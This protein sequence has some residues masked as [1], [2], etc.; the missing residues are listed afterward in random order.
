[1]KNI[2]EQTKNNINILYEEEYSQ[3]ENEIKHIIVKQLD[4]VGIMCRVFSRTKSKESVLKKMDNKRM[5]KYQAENRGMQDIL[6]IRVIVYFEDDIDICIN[7]I[8]NKFELI[9]CEHDVN[10][11]EKFCPKRINYI[12]GIPKECGEIPKEIRTKCMME[13]TFEVQFRTVFSEGWH[14]VEH[15]LRYKNQSDWEDEKDLAR[16]LNALF[17]VLEMC[18]SNLLGICDN[19]AYKKYKSRNWESM[20]RNRFRLR[21]EDKQLTKKI[22]DVFEENDSIGKDIFRFERSHLISILNEMGE[23]ITYENVIFIVNYCKTRDDMLMC[24]TPSSIMDRLEELD[25]NKLEY[26]NKMPYKS[27]VSMKYV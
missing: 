22:L 16:D 12:F 27:V 20:I 21:F 17:A 1:M 19:L 13:N 4:S 2:L 9:S 6:G 7:L 18:D 3:I 23:R 14:E 11:T 26:E 8:S 15:D 24:L 25:V 10:D 5:K